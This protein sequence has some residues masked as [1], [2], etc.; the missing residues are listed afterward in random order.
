MFVKCFCLEENLSKVS[1]IIGPT[2]D[3]SPALA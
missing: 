1:V 2:Q 3:V